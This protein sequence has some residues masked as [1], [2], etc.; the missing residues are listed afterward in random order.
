LHSPF[1]YR[2]TTA[3]VIFLL[4]GVLFGLLITPRLVDL[5]VAVCVSLTATFYIAWLGGT[6]LGLATMAVD[7][8]DPMVT[9]TSAAVVVEVQDLGPHL[10]CSECGPVQLDSK[11]CWSCNKCVSTFDH[12]CP[13]LNTCIGERNYRIFFSTICFVLVMLGTM[14]AGA[15]LLLID[16]PEN[17]GWTVFWL[18]VGA[19]VVNVPVGILDAGLLGFHCFFCWRDLTTY[20][21]ITG[22]KRSKPPKMVMPANAKVAKQEHGRIQERPSSSSTISSRSWCVEAGRVAAKHS[23][24]EPPT[25]TQPGKKMCRAKSIVSLDSTLS[26]GS[27]LA[28]TV[29]RT[30]SEF[31]FGL[32]PDVPQEEPRQPVPVAAVLPQPAAARFAEVAQQPAAAAVARYAL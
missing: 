6:A 18:L 15:V 9:C 28:A 16:G 2:Q 4:D 13:W 19:L 21:Y 23:Q 27:T 32:H 8:L 10:E 1:S 30:V 24:P 20:E 31:M 29:S 7:P 25:A 12:H 3:I 22:K 17:C 26:G 5:S 14:I 11:H